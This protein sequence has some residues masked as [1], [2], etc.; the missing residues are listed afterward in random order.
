MR[1]DS[2]TLRTSCL[3]AGVFFFT[4]FAGAGSDAAGGSPNDG[5][6]A[7]RIQRVENGIPSIS[8]GADKPPLELNIARLMEIYKVPAVSVAVIDNFKI[9]WAKAYG[10][11]EAGGTT[12][13]T[14]HTLFQA[15]SVSK[16]V[17]ASGALWLVEHGKL[18]LD[19]D[20]NQKLVTWKVPE[21]EFTKDQ[22]VT[23]RRLQ[24]HSAGLTVHG[25]PGY[26]VGD[27]IPSLVQIFNGERPANTAPIR[28][29]SVPGSKL[30]YSGGGVTIEQQLIMDVSGQQFPQ[31]MRTTVL[32]KIGMSDSTYEQPL[33]A[34]R[35]A[36]AASGTHG[37]GKVVS[38]KWH[39]YP[40]MA[41][42]GLWTTPTDSAKFGIEIALSKQGEA[43]HILS[44]AMTRQ[45][46]TPQIEHVGLAFF[47]GRGGNPEAF[48]HDGDDE[49]FQAEL[50]MF[51]D[52]GKGVAVM[53]NSENGLALA[54]YLVQSIAREYSWNYT[55]EENASDL[56]WLVA[57]ARGTQ[58]AMEKYA[59]LKKTSPKDLDENTLIQL[60]YRTLFAGKVE[61]AIQV[62]KVEVQDYP[63]YWN[64]YDS[65][66]EAYMSAKRNDV[67]IENYEKSIALK[68]DNQNGIDMLKKIRAQK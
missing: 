60:A 26:A 46:L 2:R 12:P 32:D 54:S 7:V 62:F 18:S 51:A 14:T 22:K 6:V 63:N 39:I 50:L 23:L 65:L 21:N 61:E 25:F 38:G 5:Q 4:V 24:S 64:A 47:L 40:E 30:W 49:G 28:V 8:L 17:A 52:S 1:T 15:G 43:N 13:V 58:T 56:L 42:A 35:A 20:V 3:T 41:A 9:A 36:V 67:A 59:E 19:E 57:G 31:F 33:P 16:T 27:P 66:G 37:D 55:S 45:M 53:A 29:D 68:P 10:V 34:A 44:E 48:G 11:T